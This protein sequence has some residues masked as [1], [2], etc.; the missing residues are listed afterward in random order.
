MRKLLFG[1]IAIAVMMATPALGADL[2]VKALPYKAVPIVEAPSWTGFYVGAELG[3]NWSS[4]RWTTTSLVNTGTGLPITGI[5]TSSPRNFNTAGARGG[6]YFGYNW[7]LTP[8]WV[9]GLEGDV[10]YSGNKATAAGIPGCTIRCTAPFG[11]ALG[12][13]QSSVRI[14]WDASAR[15]RLGFLVTPQ[16]LIYG[17][18]GAAWQNIQ[19]S[20]TCQHSAPDPFCG[21]SAGSPIST[22][23]NTF[24]QLGWTAGIGV[25]WRVS[26]NWIARGEYRYAQFGSDGLLNLSI[27]TTTSTI[28]YHL[29]TSSNIATLG[30]AYQFGGP[31]VAKY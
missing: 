8:Q 20:A 9:W 13:D 25:D 27:P 22:D 17:T 15:A 28:G 29:R 16:T 5:D 21:F 31:V 4:S 11:S 19:T 23:Q 30:I 1:G 12:P 24:T 7:Q 14:G 6:G 2:P 3:A 26:G 10:A 18:A